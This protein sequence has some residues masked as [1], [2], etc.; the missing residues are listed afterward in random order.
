MS[1]EHSPARAEGPS[2]DV[3][4]SGVLDDY[5]TPEQLAD[6]LGISTRTLYRW[7]RVWGDAPPVT[8]VGRRLLFRRAAVDSWLRSL[9]R[10]DAA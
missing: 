9:E 6:E 8:K 7:R 3:S 5:L 10:G 2:S 4:V 1:L